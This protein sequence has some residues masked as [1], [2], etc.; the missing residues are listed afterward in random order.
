MKKVV[1]LTLALQLVMELMDQAGLKGRK[2]QLG[3][4]FLKEIEK[5]VLV[6]YNQLYNNDPEAALN[7]MNFK[8]ILITNIAELDEPDAIL[9]SDVINKFKESIE[10]IRKTKV[11]NF[12][13]LL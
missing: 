3:N 5:D 1:E 13:K 2:K 10:D 7:A 9:L 8:N 6:N 4:M 11:T 12:N